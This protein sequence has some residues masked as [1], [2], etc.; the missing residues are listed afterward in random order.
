VKRPAVATA[1]AGLLGAL[2]AAACEEPQTVVCEGSVKVVDGK[3]TCVPKASEPEGEPSG[4]GEPEPEPQE[5]PSAGPGAEPAPEPEAGGAEPEVDPAEYD[6]PEPLLGVKEMGA[7]CTKHCECAT[8][9][10]YD[11]AYM[12]GFRFCTRDC[13]GDCGNDNEYV[14][15][16]LP[17]S[18]LKDYASPLPHICQRVCQTVDDCA[19]FGSGYDQC[20][21]LT[22]TIWKGKTL[23]TTKTCQVSEFLE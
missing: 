23:H 21:S 1:L 5:E 18:E 2:G 4:Q 14:C 19:P 3:E 17:P 6:C 8:N 22:G 10:C 16:I 9:Y 20:G 15:L 7:V 11:Q 12:A 13:E